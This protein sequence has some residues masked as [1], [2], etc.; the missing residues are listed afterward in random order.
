MSLMTFLINMPD[1]F[2]P[3]FADETPTTPQNGEPAWTQ[4]RGYTYFGVLSDLHVTNR[5]MGKI[6]IPRKDMPSFHIW[7]GYDEQIVWDEAKGIW[8]APADWD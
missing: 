6:I 8:F 3:G 7:V 1:S 4:Y 2:V 5:A